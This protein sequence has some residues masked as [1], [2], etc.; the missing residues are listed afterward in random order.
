MASQEEATG[1]EPSKE[2]APCEE[3]NPKIPQHA[4]GTLTSPTVSIPDITELN[5]KRQK[6]QILHATHSDT[7]EM[8]A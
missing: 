8:L 4:A 5:C 7:E 6:L 2:T 1:I 3:R